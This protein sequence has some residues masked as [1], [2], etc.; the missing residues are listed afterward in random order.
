MVDPIWQPSP[1]VAEIKTWLG[2]VL[3]AAMGGKPLTMHQEV[4]PPETLV[5]FVIVSML[6]GS[7]PVAAAAQSGF[8]DILGLQ[9]GLRAVCA[10]ETE[11]RALFDMIRARVAAR[12][13]AGYVTAMALTTAKVITREANY[14]GFPDL[15][16]G[17]WQQFET[18]EITY[19]RP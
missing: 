3:P 8:H 18:F 12:T 7:T 10:T 15:V 9:L 19:Q 13:R 5:P 17:L 2:G 11:T 6:P 14:D 4:P 1:V 16:G